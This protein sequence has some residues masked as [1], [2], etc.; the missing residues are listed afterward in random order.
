VKE[1]MNFADKLDIQSLVI[2]RFLRALISSE[3]DNIFSISQWQNRAK[4]GFFLLIMLPTF[5][6]AVLLLAQQ[7]ETVWFGLVSPPCNL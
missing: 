6:N 3:I 2:L 4:P 7:P 1:F 5:Y